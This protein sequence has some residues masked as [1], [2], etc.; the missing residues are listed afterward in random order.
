MAVNG[1]KHCLGEVSLA[2]S[3]CLPSG[4][5]NPAPTSD[6]KIRSKYFGPPVEQN[7]RRGGV[8]RPNITGLIN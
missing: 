1:F 2:L 8:P 5:G 7:G 3:T 6:Y 4:R